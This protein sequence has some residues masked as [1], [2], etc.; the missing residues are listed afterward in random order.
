EL[1]SWMRAQAG[2]SSLRAILYMDEVFGYLP[3]T[4]NPPSK[5][6]LL[7]LL[8]QARAF[9]LGLV[10]A[11]QNPV[12]LDYK[13]L[14]NAGTWF[15]GR[16]QTERDKLRVLDGLEGASA[17]AGAEFDR[18][19][20]EQILSAVGQ[21]VFLLNNVHEDRPVVFHTRWALSYLS[22]PMTRDQILS[23]MQSR[24]AASPSPGPASVAAGMTSAVA[25]VAPTQFPPQPVEEK[26]RRPLL[27]DSID[28]RFASVSRSVPRDAPIAY[29][30]AILGIGK[31]H[32][33]D[34]KAGIDEWRDVM[35]VCR[36]DDEPPAAV[37]D[38]A[39]NLDAHP[40]ELE[41]SPCPDAAWNEL[42]SSM[43]KV[44]SYKSWGSRLK[45]ALYRDTH[46]TVLSCPDLD[47]YSR[48][49]QSEGDFRVE[50]K[51]QAREQRDIA[52][53]KLRQK[54]GEKIAK[55]EEA[56]RT[57]EHRVAAEEEQAKEASM[58]A[59]VATGTSI[60]GALFGRKKVSVT[61]IG[62]AGSAAKAHS[63]ASQQKADIERAEEKLEDEVAEKEA[64]EEELEQQIDELSDQF[65][66]ERLK[67]ETIAVSPRK[68]DIIVNLTGLLW[69]PWRVDAG[70]L[71]EPAWDQQDAPA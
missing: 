31:L 1:I 30:P 28:Q 67:I 26:P 46:L 68:S 33:V 54:Y 22:G 52:I 39:D 55:Q 71:A 27:H 7:T 6:P 17:A 9:G 15:L 38:D 44:S 32:F 21:R 19:R 42:P 14:S 66:V 23:L 59:W 64:L 10:L 65:D 47:V 11:T 5:L 70:G 35:R 16:L 8:K 12:D 4:A 48:P 25:S 51:Q 62:R 61:N 24:K 37:W 36:V 40:L 49:G 2:T 29:R 13:A 41:T 57:A 69:Q 53:E 50:L 34:S 18:A 20:M 63:R 60:L 45:A 3:P 56:I 43:T 58:S